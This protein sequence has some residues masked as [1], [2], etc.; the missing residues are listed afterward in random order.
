VAVLSVASLGEAWQLHNAKSQVHTAQARVGSLQTQVSELQT[1]TA[2]HGK[3][4]ARE[5]LVVTALTG[6]IDWVRVLK[7]LS[8]VM[9]PN[10]SLTSFSGSRASAAPGSSTTSSPST[11]ASS[12]N[13][14]FTVT[15]K[16]GLPAVAA[17][18]DGLQRDH[19]LQ[20][21]WVS[22]ISTT[23][24]GGTVT[25]SST[26]NLTPLADSNRAQAVKS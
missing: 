8:A 10:L 13:L 6:D 3:V 11:G 2:V 1:R 14:T 23:S 21:T 4:Q 7:Q 12:G 26:T 22:G 19:A 15:G 9:P 24:N 25:F 20:G 16:G 17:W 5:A 18:L